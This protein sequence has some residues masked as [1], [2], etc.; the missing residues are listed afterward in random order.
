MAWAVVLFLVMGVVFWLMTGDI[1]ALI[2]MGAFA[3]AIGAIGINTWLYWR[4]K[5]REEP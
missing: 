2:F 1:A 3:A 4:K 5:Q